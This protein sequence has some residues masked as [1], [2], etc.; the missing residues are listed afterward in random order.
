MLP[1]VTDHRPSENHP[2]MILPSSLYCAI[3]RLE[4]A[5]EA[6]PPSSACPHCQH[7]VFGPGWWCDNCNICVFPGMILD[8]DY[9]PEPVEPDD[10]EEPDDDYR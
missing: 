9:E 6:E 3:P 7:P 1:N 8:A 10:D 5:L 4:A 2:V